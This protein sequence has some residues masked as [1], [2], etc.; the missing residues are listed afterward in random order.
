MFFDALEWLSLFF[1]IATVILLFFNDTIVKRW[2]KYIAIWFL[3]LS[4][5]FSIVGAGSGLLQPS[6]DDLSILTG[7]MLVGITLIFALYNRFYRKTGV[8]N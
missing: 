1:L 2:F 4:F 7:Q 6:T 5:V 8:S 3:P